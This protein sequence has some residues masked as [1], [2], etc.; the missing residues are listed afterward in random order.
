MDMITQYLPRYDVNLYVQ[1]QSDA[2]DHDCPYCH[3]TS[4]YTL[5]NLESQIRLTLKFVLVC[6][7]TLR[8]KKAGR[9]HIRDELYR[10]LMTTY[11]TV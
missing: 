3:R 2:G 8:D 6:Q 11:S 1:E 10:E 9:C 4:Q 7:G 5:P